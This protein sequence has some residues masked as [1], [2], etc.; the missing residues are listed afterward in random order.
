MSATSSHQYWMAEAIKLAARGLYSTHPNPRVGCV[1][2]KQNKIVSSGWH[3][4]TGGPHA[5]INAL[6]PLQGETG[7]DVYITLEPCSHHGRTPPCVDALIKYRPDRVIVAMQDPNPLV[8]G[9]GLQKLKDANIEVIVG[10]QESEA[11]QLNCGFVKRFDKKRPFVRLKMATSLD[12]RTA[13]KNGHSQWISGEPSRR[14]V[15]YLRA[16]SS[17][18]LTSAATVVADDPQLDV[19][20]SREE[21][22]QACE[23]RQPLRVVVDSRLILTGKEKIFKQGAPVW[24]Y[25]VIDDQSKHQQL[26]AAGAEVIVSEASSD[27]RVDLGLL[28]NDLAAR[29]INEVHTECGQT[30]AGALLRQKL[31]DEIVIYMAP[32]LLGSQA[33]GAFDIGELTDMNSRVACNIQQIRQ[34]GDDLRVAL[35]PE[36]S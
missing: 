25:T 33:R 2:I 1:V 27:G 30:L 9:K 12:G 21:L 4:C 8:A 7:G 16:R 10:V 15:Q 26:I 11:R 24:I 31:V 22:G 5:E 3:E 35:I 18:N 19:R 17:A 13:L 23:V 34:V 14:D 29:E 28:L 32:V 36:Y 20:L 6:E